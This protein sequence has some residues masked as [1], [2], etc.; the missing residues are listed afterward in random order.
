MED[1]KRRLLA[2]FVGAFALTFIGGGAIIMTQGGDLVAI[3]LAHGVTIA[4][5]VCALGHISGGHFNPAVSLAMLITGRLK[6][7]EFA[8][9]VAAQCVGALAAAAILAGIHST[10]L[11]KTASPALGSGVS[12]GSG[13]V[14][15]IIMT[16]FLVFVIFGVAVD[17]KGTF[18]AVAGLPIGLTITVDIFLGG[19]LTGAAMNPSRWI[20]TAIV[21]GQWDNFWIWI[22]GP[23]VGAAIAALLYQN[24]M[25]PAEA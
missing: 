12:V 1:A 7:N 6:T 13:L 25:K 2:E 4:V 14:L 17:P 21:G 10:D 5:M 23:G 19:G 8:G 20:G 22:V 3:A 9:Y 18:A 24:V 15:E 16:F 11:V